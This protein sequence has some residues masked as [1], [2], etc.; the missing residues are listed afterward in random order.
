[1]L[2]VLHS[3]SYL[4]ILLNPPSTHVSFFPHFKDE[5]A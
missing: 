3:A 2:N 4:I 1:M 5:E